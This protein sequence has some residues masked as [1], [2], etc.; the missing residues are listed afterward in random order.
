MYK[1][2][3]KVQV[4]SS[5]VDWLVSMTSEGILFRRVAAVHVTYHNDS[6]ARMFQCLLLLFFSS[7]SI[8]SGHD[9][10]FLF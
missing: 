4:D 10:G 2:F 9:L 6:G 1:G 5:E 7:F 8:F 3:S